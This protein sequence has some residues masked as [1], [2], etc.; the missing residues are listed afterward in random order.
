[1]NNNMKRSLA[2]LIAALH[3]L[4]FSVPADAAEEAV[5][6]AALALERV[7]SALQG[8]TAAKV[9]VVPNRLVNIVAR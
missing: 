4:T 6:D 2:A 3:I 8:K 9:I 7:R 1:M 5:K